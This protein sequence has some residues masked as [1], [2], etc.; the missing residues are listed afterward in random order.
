MND[1]WDWMS[2]HKPETASVIIGT[3][4]FLF[5]GAR[6][7]MTPPMASFIGAGVG[8]LVY[9][10]IWGF[11]RIIDT[12]NVQES[13]LWDV[14][15]SYYNAFINILAA[16]ILIG[17]LVVGYF[18]GYLMASDPGTAILQG[19]LGALG[20][21]FALA[22]LAILPATK[23]CDAMPFAVTVCFP[24]VVAFTIFLFIYVLVE[25]GYRRL[26]SDHNA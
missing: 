16:I 10:V 26:T 19:L 8:A 24:A 3:I 17:W 2:D 18:I 1:A 11:I 25:T 6:G 9:G 12:N 4:V 13:T 22:V 5:F 14:I 20:A 23:R 21:F 15:D 7:P